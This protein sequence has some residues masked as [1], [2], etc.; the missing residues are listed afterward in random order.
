MLVRRLL[1]GFLVVAVAVSL[2]IP[3]V[4]QDKDKAKA[5]D[6]DKEKAKEKE[7]AK[8]DEPAK[9]TGDKVGIKWKFEKGKAFYQKMV[10]KTVQ[11]M[12][13]MNNDVHQTQN[14]TFYFKFEPT[15]VAADKVSIE[16]TITGVAMDIEIGGSKISFD[17]TKEQAANNPL[18][19][20]FKA[21]IGSKFTIDLDPKDNKV[22]KVE[23]RDAFIAKLVAAN[24]QMKPLLETILSN[25]AL[26]EM[27]EPTFAVVPP[28][29]D[30]AKGET[31]TRSSKLDMGPI[32]KY[33]NTYK[34][35]SEG[36]DATDKAIQLIKVD[37]ELAYKEPG[38]VAGA[39]GLPFK[40]KTAKLKSSNPKGMVRFNTA[41]GRLDKS[42]TTLE[43]KGDLVIEI[44]GQNT[45]VGLSQSQV[46][47]I[48]TTDE[49]PMAKK[50]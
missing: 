31:W 13:V 26:K 17:S 35:T 49:D 9:A 27:A 39:G 22:I 40:I 4:A 20:F 29:G 3:A 18:G 25:E 34:Y 48:E 12:K 23:G 2:A 21:L 33:E 28:K 45:T 38:D 19:E 6:K 5:K 24:P 1:A 37:T 41:K 47:T 32:G 16:Q 46:S 36:A 42:E 11:T 30:A 10:T 44:G 8:K 7:P 50:K 43:L 15:A 14:Q